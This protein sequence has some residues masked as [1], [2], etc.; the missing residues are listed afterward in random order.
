MQANPEKSDEP[1]FKYKENNECYKH[2]YLEKSKD[3]STTI[4]LHLYLESHNNLKCI[5]IVHRMHQ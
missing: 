4:L 2:Q 1:E 3:T 5:A